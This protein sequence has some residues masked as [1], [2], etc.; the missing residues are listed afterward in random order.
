VTLK[1]DWII[2]GPVVSADANQIRQVLINLVTNAWEAIG[3]NRGSIH[4]QIK[5]VS[6]SDIPT[7]HRF[8]IDWQPHDQVYACLEVADSGSGISDQDMENLFDPFF[9]DKFTG[10]GMGLP[11]VLGIVKTHGGAITVISKRGHGSII[12]IFL[13]VFAGEIS[14]RADKAVQATDIKMDGTLLLVDDDAMLRNMAAAMIKR[15]GFTVIEAKDGVEAM[16]VFL[17]HKDEIRCV[18]TDLTMPRMNGWET[19][20]ALRKLKP[21]IPVILASGYDAAQVMAGDHPEKPQTFLGKPYKLK[22]L[23]DAIHRALGHQEKSS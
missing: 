2:P 7:L 6:R 16:E 1:S 4:L 8:P 10:R 3:K 23:S 14:R 9:S 11:V 5:T 20:T 17:Q 12:R 15:L 18:L 22:E 19:L 21:D 13:P